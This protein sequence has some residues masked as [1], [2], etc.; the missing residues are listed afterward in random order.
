MAHF[1]DSPEIIVLD[2]TPSTNTALKN[3]LNL[4]KL[5]EFSMVITEHQTAGRGQLGN[6]WESE[7]SANLTFSLLLRPTFLE[8]H[9]Q[10]Y[11]SKIISLAIV[12]TLHDHQIEAAIKWPNDI[13]INDNK[14]AG[15][16]IE[17]S[18]TG[19]H[20]DS[21]VVGIGLNVNQREF[22]S[23]APNPISLKQ[24]TGATIDLEMLLKQLIEAIITRYHQL[25]EGQLAEIDELYFQKLYRHSG[26]HSFRD[27]NGY[28][29]ATIQTVQPDGILSLLDAEAQIRQYA[30]KEVEFII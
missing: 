13:Y 26:V 22:T 14:A 12:D 11:I 8:P 19:S 6:F 27:Q 23:D 20:M 9:L 10:F 2:N 3:K 18:L 28:F 21:T 15:I 4:Q 24:V 7:K 17:S 25:A 5:P 1:N 16:L 29:M 30:F